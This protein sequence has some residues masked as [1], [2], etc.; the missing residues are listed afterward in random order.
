MAETKKL[1]I[2][3]LKF[4]AKVGLEAVQGVKT[5]NVIAQDYGMHSVQV[6]KWNR[7]IKAKKLF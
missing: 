3:L 4:K 7:E 6:S 5:I 1:S 2:H